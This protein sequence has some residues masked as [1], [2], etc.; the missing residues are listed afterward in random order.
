MAVTG[1]DRAEVIR[2]FYERGGCV[3]VKLDVGGH[4]LTLKQALLVCAGA[5]R[6]D[7]PCEFLWHS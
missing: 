3:S 5:K 7:W 2:K 1:Y 6:E 4:M